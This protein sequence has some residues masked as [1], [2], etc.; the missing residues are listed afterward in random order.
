MS[1]H[2]SV[3]KSAKAVSGNIAGFGQPV[4]FRSSSGFGQSG[5]FGG[6]GSGVSGLSYLAEYPDTSELS[7]PQV[8]VTF[9]NLGKRDTKTKTK[10]LE[11]LKAVLEDVLSSDTPRTLEDP[12]ISVWVSELV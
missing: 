2:K 8:V 12:I 4:S 3:A 6:F 10:A 7:D 1:K 5:A 9:K 11:E